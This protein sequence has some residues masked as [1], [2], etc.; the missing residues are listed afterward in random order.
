[1]SRESV[2]VLYRLYDA[3]NRR[4]FD[5]FITL[6]DPEVEFV[7]GAHVLEGRSGRGHDEMRGWWEELLS[8]YP[9]WNAE[10]VEIQVRAGRYVATLRMRGHG[11][12]SDVPVD[13]TIW[14]VSEVRGGRVVSW[15][16]WRTEVEALVAVGLRE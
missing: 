3:F 14:M 16:T 12:Q 2:E 10:V 13:T 11:A 5:E 9:D 7:A 4:D 6:V 8:V 1:M 15:R